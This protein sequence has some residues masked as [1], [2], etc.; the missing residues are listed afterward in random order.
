MHSGIH[1][2]PIIGIEKH[3]IL[4]YIVLKLQITLCLKITSILR[5][6]LDCPWNNMALS[7]IN[8]AGLMNWQKSSAFMRRSHTQGIIDSF[9]REIGVSGSGHNFILETPFIW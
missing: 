4:F 7:W 5:H 9:Q 2:Y 8:S 3:I 6:L 1:C